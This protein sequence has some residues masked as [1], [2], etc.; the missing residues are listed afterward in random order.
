MFLVQPD[1]N[2]YNIS[3]VRSAHGTAG[4]DFSGRHSMSRL[5]AIVGLAL[6]TAAPRDAQSADMKPASRVAILRGLIAESATVLA[7]L[8]R[9]NKGLRMAAEGGVDR[10]SLNH[11]L[12]Q[13]GTAVQSKTIVQITSI[14]FNDK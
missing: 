6:V 14:D 9:G 7:P 4:R 10:D 12:T 1:G 8:P 2:G 3:T 5:L 11:E 13:E